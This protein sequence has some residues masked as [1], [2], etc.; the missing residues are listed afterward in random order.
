M[1]DTMSLFAQSHFCTFARAATLMASVKTEG[2]R[3][4]QQWQPPARECSLSTSVPE[5]LAAHTVDL[6]VYVQA[7]H[8]APTPGSR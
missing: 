6:G 7:V 5:P 2:C 4:P 1:W 3:E 8:A